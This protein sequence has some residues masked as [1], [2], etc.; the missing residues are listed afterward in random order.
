[1]KRETVPS[2]DRL[3]LHKMTFIK[4]VTMFPE[5]QQIVD[6]KAGRLSVQSGMPIKNKT[7]NSGDAICDEVEMDNASDEAL[8]DFMKNYEDN[9]KDAT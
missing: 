9:I 6:L 4:Y 5:G 3:F 7:S 2:T 8:L 1:M